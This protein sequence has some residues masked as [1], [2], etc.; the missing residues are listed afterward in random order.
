MPR[1]A[2]FVLAGGQSSR[3]GTDKAMLPYQGTVLVDFVARRVES[4]AGTVTIV[5]DPGRYSHLGRPVVPDLRPGHGPLSGIETA[6]SLRQAD[7]NLVV[8]CDLPGVDEG[9]L[10]RLKAS[11]EQSAG[12]DCVMPLGEQGRPEPL[13]A[14]YRATCLPMVSRAL[15]EERR[16]VTSAFEQAQVIYLQLDD[17]STLRNMN[18]PGDWAGFLAATPTNG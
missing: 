6:L 14:A 7:W 4:V 18:S 13:C 8:A 12:A 11:V 5:G 15:D 10:G 9:L 16:K 3:M 17:A 2:G 1:F